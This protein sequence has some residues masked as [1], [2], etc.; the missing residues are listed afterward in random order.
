MAAPIEDYAIIGD[1]ET[2]ALVSRA[3]SIDWFCAPR[4]DS[5]ACLAGLL[6]GDEHGAWSLAPID[7][8]V[9]ISRTYRG[10]TLVLETLYTTASGSV[11]VI[12][13]MP[14]RGMVMPEVTDDGS[15]SSRRDV[16]PERRQRYPSI[17]RVIEGISGQV[18]MRSTQTARF[19]YGGIVPWVRHHDGGFLAVA[20]ADALVTY[21]DVAIE[22][23][24]LEHVGEF[25]VAAGERRRFSMSYYPS[26]LTCPECFDVDISL[27]VTQ[28]WWE[29]WADRCD[30][31]GPWRDAM[32]RSLLTLKA[33]TYAPT[34]G[35]VAAA[36][37]SLPE[38]IGSVR[39]WDYRYC[40]LRDATFTLQ[41]LLEAGYDDEAAAWSD[42]LRRSVAGD[43]DKMQIMYGV[44]GERR[45][46]EYEVEWLPGYEA[47]A[48]VRVGNAASGQFQL[49]VYGEVMDMF[50]TAETEQ[51]MHRTEHGEQVRG[52]PDDAIDLAR[53]LVDHVA[54]VWREADDGIWEVRGPRRHFVHSK[55]MAW[56]AVSRFL[57]LLDVL[58]LTDDPGPWRDLAAEIHADV[59]TNGFNAEL[60]S[61]TQYYGSTNLDAS[62]LIIGIEGFLAPDDPRLIGTIEAVERSLLKDGFVLRYE[63]DAT[64]DATGGGEGT[65]TGP[66]GER[67]DTVDGLPPGE[68]AFLLTTFWLLDVL[69]LV[70]RV[71]DAATI[72]ERLLALRNDVGLLAEEY[73]PVAQRFLGNFPQAFSHVGLLNSGF[74]LHRLGVTPAAGSSTPSSQPPTGSP[75]S[76]Q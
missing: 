40:W 4:F 48:P 60:N 3:G 42:W 56:V 1:T 62:L 50:L 55:V 8:D 31:D 32:M 66:D 75:A 24:H 39:N 36:T 63:T 46:M 28:K 74:N 49:D 67:S 16:P 7:P 44:G 58:D 12:D 35:I 68:G 2:V 59:C 29:R 71:D 45:L 15:A 57:Q 73:D 33:L 20:G 10:D 26:H 25:T 41:V 19:D 23:R 18:A 5:A 30:Y 9:S 38:W 27:A 52:L 70:G 64:A 11:A 53:F 17:V 61:F 76:G 65:R 34:G 6:G 47:S 22:G 21:S 69:A 14:I 51:L 13:F 54:T 72:F 43:P 37:T